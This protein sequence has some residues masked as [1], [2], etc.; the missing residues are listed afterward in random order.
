MALYNYVWSLILVSSYVL[1]NLNQL[2]SLSILNHRTDNIIRLSAL[3][4]RRQKKKKNY[5]KWQ[6]GT[7]TRNP[8]DV[9]EATTAMIPI[10]T[11]LKCVV[12]LT[13]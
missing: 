6:T 8:P 12:I 3:I 7:R 2:D 5:T 13:S 4:S 1:I 10:V 9:K 11:S